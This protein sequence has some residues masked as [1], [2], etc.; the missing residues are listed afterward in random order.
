MHAARVVNAMQEVRSSSS[1][2]FFF[3]CS[4][5]SSVFGTEV[6]GESKTKITIDERTVLCARGMLD[7][8]AW[9]TAHGKHVLDQPVRTLSR[10]CNTLLGPFHL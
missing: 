9:T 8:L 10:L 7:L 1:W 4:K 6:R 3:A 2:S 5:S